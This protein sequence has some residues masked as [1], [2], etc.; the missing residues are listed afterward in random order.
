MKGTRPARLGRLVGARGASAGAAAQRGFTLI[1]TLVALAVLGTVMSVVYGMV[2]DQLRRIGR[3]DERVTLALFAENLLARTD[4]DLGRPGAPVTGS[5]ADGLRWTIERIPVPLP[6]LP[7]LDAGAADATDGPAADAGGTGSD[8]GSATSL[9]PQPTPASTGGNADVGPGAAP[10][11]AQGGANAPRKE[12]QLV[13]VRVT[14]ANAR[15]E[16][17]ALSTLRVEAR[18]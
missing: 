1:E 11:T 15:G 18:P 7:P 5:T 17:V 3:G 4:L 14:A 8:A 9:L 2:S 6:P 12:P 10:G 13:E 16:E